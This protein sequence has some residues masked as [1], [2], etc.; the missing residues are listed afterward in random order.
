MSTTSVKCCAEFGG[1]VG[2]IEGLPFIEAI[3]Q[4]RNE[5]GRE[6]TD[7]IHIDL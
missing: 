6:Q 2:D 3:R 5:L 4:L 7:A 1:T